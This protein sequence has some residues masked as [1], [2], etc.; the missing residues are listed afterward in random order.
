MHLLYFQ[1]SEEDL[2]PDLSVLPSKM[3]EALG[4]G[5]TEDAVGGWNVP[6]PDDAGVG[7]P[8]PYMARGMLSRGAHKSLKQSQVSLLQKEMDHPGG[9]KVTLRR[10][11]CHHAIALVEAFGSVW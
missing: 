11:D 1:V 10:V 7:A 8:P 5:D 2:G 3:M 9:V 4:F 6:P